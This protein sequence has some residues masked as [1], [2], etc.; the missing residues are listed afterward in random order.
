MWCCLP[1]PK[2]M[3]AGTFKTWIVS[4]FDTPA[5]GASEPAGS[6]QHGFEIIIFNA[7]RAADDFGHGP[8]H[9]P[10]RIVH[11]RCESTPGIIPIVPNSASVDHDHWKSFNLALIAL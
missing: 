10:L 11:L 7:V 2:L 1:A 5:T 6:Y 9:L 4:H 3:R 8:F